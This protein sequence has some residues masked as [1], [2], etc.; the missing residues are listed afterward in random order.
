MS[1]TKNAVLSL[2]QQVLS[3]AGPD[4]VARFLPLLREPKVLAV[5]GTSRSTLWANIKE[6]Y[7]VPPVKIGPGRAVG[8]PQGEILVVIRARIAGKSNDE[9]RRLVKDLVAARLVAA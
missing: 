5:T 6:G 2:A 7:F 9:I 4:P 3:S 8:W 1:N